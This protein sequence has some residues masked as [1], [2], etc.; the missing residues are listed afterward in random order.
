MTTK[1]ISLTTHSYFISTFSSILLI[2]ATSSVA[3]AKEPEITNDVPPPP[4]LS[5]Q[6]QLIKHKYTP[7]VPVNTD[8]PTYSRN[9]RQKE[10]TFSAPDESTLKEVDSELSQNYR[11]EVFGDT[12]E[13]LAEVRNI[14][15]KAYQKGDIIQVGIFSD[16]NN[17]QDLVRKLAM[18]G[19]W[20][21]IVVNY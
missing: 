8:P 5:P 15:P 2:L 6:N 13:M 19:L 4:P 20:S 7:I 9:N 16:R 18:Q 11:V 12:K 10:Y 3:T 1:S 14:E 17:A 21:R